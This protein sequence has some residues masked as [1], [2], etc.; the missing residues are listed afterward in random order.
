MRFEIEKP[1]IR[2][3]LSYALKTSI[4]KDAI[5]N[6]GIDYNIHLIY[7]QTYSIPVGETIFECHYLLPNENVDYDRLY[8]QAGTVKSEDRK[9][10]ETLLK[11][12]V[13]PK[14]ID[15][16]SKIQ[17][18][19]DLST[20]LKNKLYFNAIFKDNEVAIYCDEV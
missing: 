17:S 15:W 2:K 3:G 7:W 13:I 9:N 5:D 12:K 8:I 14:F 11:E 20:K 4:L 19:P 6:A 10:A 1:K 16:V 18:L